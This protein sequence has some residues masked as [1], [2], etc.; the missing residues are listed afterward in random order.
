MITPKIAV[1]SNKGKTWEPA[2]EFTE[3]KRK[4]ETDDPYIYTQKL[5]TSVNG[6]KWNLL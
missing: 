5:A 1:S 4:G 3:Y 6:K 2:T